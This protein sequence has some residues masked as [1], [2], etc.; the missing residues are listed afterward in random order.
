MKPKMYMQ[1]QQD[2][3]FSCC[4]MLTFFIWKSTFVALGS[5]LLSSQI[6]EVLSTSCGMQ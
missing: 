2:Y 1:V 4:L 3:C 6:L 5:F